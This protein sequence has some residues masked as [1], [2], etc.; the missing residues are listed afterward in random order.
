[1]QGLLSDRLSLKISQTNRSSNMLK[2][3]NSSL[4]KPSFETQ[5]AFPI[6]YSFH[7]RNRMRERIISKGDVDRV[8]SEGN[9]RLIPNGRKREFYAVLPNGLGL[10][11]VMAANTRFVI[12]AYFERRLQIK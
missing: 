3:R 10:R 2:Q 8:V 1:V 6:A 12:T 7:A 11:V 4:A 5:P 9:V